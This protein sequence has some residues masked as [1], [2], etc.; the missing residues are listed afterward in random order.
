MIMSWA[1]LLD[2]RVG[3]MAGISSKVSQRRCQYADSG[4]RCSRGPARKSAPREP[5]YGRHHRTV[6]TSHLPWDRKQ[7]VWSQKWSS[8]G[9]RARRRPTTRWSAPCSGPGARERP[10]GPT[11]MPPRR[12]S[13]SC[14][15]LKRQPTPLR[16]RPPR[17]LSQMTRPRNRLAG[18][19]TP[20]YS[21]QPASSACCRASDV[22]PTD[23]EQAAELERLPAA[24]A[25]LMTSAIAAFAGHQL[26]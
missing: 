9:L 11:R 1:R 2:L 24:R 12:W 26:N 23:R 21:L 7:A 19:L 16:I 5:H 4:P 3:R 17:A 13:A 25:R 6:E 14:C 20:T 8:R 18:R 10:P 22:N 15:R